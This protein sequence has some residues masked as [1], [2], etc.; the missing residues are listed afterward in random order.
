MVRFEDR[1]TIPARSVSVEDISRMLGTEF[2]ESF[3]HSDAGT[4][5]L[6]RHVVHVVAASPT[7]RAKFARMIFGRGHHA[8]VYSD[9]GELAEHTPT[10]GVVLVLEDSECSA[11][12]VTEMLARQGAWLPVLAYAEQLD[13]DRI[14]CGVKAGVM[15]YLVGPVAPET[16]VA[17]IAKCQSDGA[18]LRNLRSR[19]ASS[20][21]LIGGLS[22]REG[23]V[24]ELLTEGMSNKE[25]ARQL[26]ISPRTVEI[27][28]MKMMAKLGA[29]SSAQAIRL[30]IEAVTIN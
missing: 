30:K 5:K 24:L 19:H 6:V 8:E 9:V 15:D 2:G 11:V 1:E 4:A 25:I 23:E 27:H 17:K 16:L 18:A 7:E 22:Q 20:R 14:V 13:A 3:A 28:R 21:A 29:K 10:D 26:Q 12:T